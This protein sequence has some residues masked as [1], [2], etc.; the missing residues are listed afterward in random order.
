MLW[1]R[2]N[3]NRLAR[4]EYFFFHV[5]HSCIVVACTYACTRHRRERGRGRRERKRERGKEGEDK[6]EGGRTEKERKIPI[7][8]LPIYFHAHFTLTLDQIS[9][10]A[11]YFFPFVFTLY[12]F[13]S[14]LTFNF[15]LYSFRMFILMLSLRPPG[16][17]LFWSFFLNLFWSCTYVYYLGRRWAEGRGKHGSRRE[18]DMYGMDTLVG[19][20]ICLWS[21][22]CMP[23]SCCLF[24]CFALLFLCLLTCFVRCFGLLWE[25]RVGPDGFFV[26]VLCGHWRC[27]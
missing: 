8:L 14:Y 11:L 5:P 10:L 2:S 22:L 20:I 23:C 4:R 19:R 7:P 1:L 16:W 15:M 3:V 21:L 13:L 6:E 9:S 18:W 12:F 27:M 17:F 24:L 26:V 25:G